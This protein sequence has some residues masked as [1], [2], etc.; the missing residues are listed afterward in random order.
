[1]E[2]IWK[3]CKLLW[4]E[5]LVLRMW[6]V[7]PALLCLKHLC[8]EHGEIHKHRHNFVKGHSIDGRIAGNAVEPASMQSR[9]D[10]LEAEIRRRAVEAGRKPPSSPFEQPDL[11]VYPPEQRDY[12]IDREAALKLLLDRC[13]E[14]RRLHIG[15]DSDDVQP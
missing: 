10:E 7:D 14:C 13:D 2:E 9:H 5:R 15:E 1:L 3:N 4:R 6:M 8:G 12:V 11:S